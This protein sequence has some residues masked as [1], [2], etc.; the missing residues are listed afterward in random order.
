MYTKCTLYLL[1]KL[2]GNIIQ[3]PVSTLLVILWFR[4]QL[5]KNKSDKKE[6]ATK[7]YEGWFYVFFF[8]Q[9]N[10]FVNWTSKLYPWII[11]LEKIAILGKSRERY[12]ALVRKADF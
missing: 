5:A 3:L 12:Q 4:R 11:N 9:V 2:N 7:S 10:F 8:W 1:M 6:Q